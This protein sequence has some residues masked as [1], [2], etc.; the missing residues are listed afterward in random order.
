MPNFFGKNFRIPASRLASDQTY[1]A[2]ELLV[3]AAQM[4]ASHDQILRTARDTPESP[5]RW[6]KML[7][8]VA[9]VGFFAGRLSLRY[10]SHTK[11]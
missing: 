9:I 8:M 10:Q 6:L 4:H 2:G 1:G 7:S 11:T 3:T 5:T